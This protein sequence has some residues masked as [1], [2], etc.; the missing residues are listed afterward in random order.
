MGTCT[1][2]A[3]GLYLRIHA[4][5]GARKVGLRGLHGDAIKVAVREVAE[6]GKANKAII[7]LVAKA[8]GLAKGA[9]TVVSGHSARSKRLYLAGDG[10]ALQRKVEA[11]IST[12]DSH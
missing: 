3:D 1:I 8:L 9:V 2:G 5:P 4:Q 7:A 12:V 6:S 10:A 11:W